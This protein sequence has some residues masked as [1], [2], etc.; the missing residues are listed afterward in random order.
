MT[1]NNFK[2]SICGSYNT[3]S[4][5]KTGVCL[6]CHT[7]YKM[8]GWIFKWKAFITTLIYAADIIIILNL[9]QRFY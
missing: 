8:D 4:K 9:I 6:D 3:V 7:F 5:G 1:F 2:C